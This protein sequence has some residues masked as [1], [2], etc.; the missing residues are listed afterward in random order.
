MSLETSN[1]YPPII[2]A[3]MPAFT[4]N[5]CNIYFSLSDFNTISDIR[6]DLV[7]VTVKN[8]K[9]NQNSLVSGN[10]ILFYTIQEDI[11]KGYYITIKDTDLVEGFQ[12]DLYYK[13]QIRFAKANINIENCYVR[14][15]PPNNPPEP[16]NPHE[17]G[18][19]EYNL[20][21]YRYELTSDTTV[22]SN[23]K[24]YNAKSSS[25]D[26]INDNLD[27]FS[28]WSSVC[29]IRAITEPELKQNCLQKLS[30][31]LYYEYSYPFLNFDGRITFTE[32]NEYLYSYRLRLY[33]T[34]DISPYNI[35]EPALED[36]G[37]QYP[38]RDNDDN[39]ILYNFK[40]KLE[41]NDTRYSLYI[42]IITN[43]LYQKTFSYEAFLSTYIASGTPSVTLTCTEEP[44]SGRAK[45]HIESTSGNNYENIIIYRTSNRSNFEEYEQIAII[46]YNLSSDFYDSS[47]ESGV[48]YKYA[49]QLYAGNNQYSLIAEQTNPILVLFED[50][51]LNS[52][53]KELR[54]RFNSRVSSYK[55]VVTE[56]K[57]ETLG[58]RYPFVRKNSATNYKQFSINGLISFYTDLVEQPPIGHTADHS[59]IISPSMNGQTGSTSIEN[60]SS[61]TNNNEGDKHIFITDRELYGGNPN[62]ETGPDILYNE[63]NLNHNITPNYDYIKERE[64]REKVLDFLCQG[65][66]I[67]LRT[68]TEGNVLVRLMDVNVTPNQSLYNYICEFTATA[69]EI[70]ECTPEN[71]Y[72][73][74]VFSYPYSI[75]QLEG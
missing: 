25:T 40:H 36:S 9:N 33:R 4:G 43:N 54:L 41:G 61:M 28:E 53:N 23:K 2:D 66:V 42:D 1:L 75:E 10:G 60:N 51:Y 15:I 3:F 45:L 20:E 56:S 12:L 50:V 32:K 72:K 22:V 49:I 48:W 34:S 70:G 13:V 5:E 18:W 11:E 29:L 39:R 19:Y 35:I 24:Y 68:L 59:Q 69:V 27:N 67:L 16:I 44:D 26:W 52:Q 37:V 7:Q 63:Y 71:Y 74:G 38:N 46:N 14:I 57:T 47:I 55:R 64:F 8:Q 6:S 31:N 58:G 30:G 65:K 73:Y 62:D 17:S 21:Q